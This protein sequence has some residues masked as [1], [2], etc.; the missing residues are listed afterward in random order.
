VGKYYRIYLVPHVVQLRL[1]LDFAKW[2][3][4]ALPTRI[5]ATGIETLSDCVKEF[6]NFARGFLPWCL[7]PLLALLSIKWTQKH[8]LEVDQK[9]KV[10][11]RIEYGLRKFL[12][13]FFG[14]G[15]QCIAKNSY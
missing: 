6:V 4:P 5:H 2:E 13:L 9:G 15:V 11:E 3:C 7:Q 14:C 8:V 12:R 1:T 10:S